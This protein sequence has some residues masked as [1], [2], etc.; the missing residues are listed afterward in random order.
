M[1]CINIQISHGLLRNMKI[2][3]VSE[4]VDD[5]N[6]TIMHTLKNNKYFPSQ[7]GQ[8]CA[9]FRVVLKY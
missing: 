4:Q 6:C 8:M 9:I 3:P 5:T 2:K 1:F 7:V